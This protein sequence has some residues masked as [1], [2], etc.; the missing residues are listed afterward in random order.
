MKNERDLFL[1]PFFTSILIGIIIGHFYFFSENN[2]FIY[3]EFK[4][5]Y[6][7]ILLHA[8]LI[9]FGYE[10]GLNL[11]YNS[12]INGISQKSNELKKQLLIQNGFTKKE[13]KRNSGDDKYIFIIGDSYMDN[14]FQYGESSYPYL[15]KKFSDSLN[16]GFVDLSKSGTDFDY[17]NETLN[18][19]N[20]KNSILVYSFYINDY[21]TIK[22]KKKKD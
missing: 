16:Y 5:K 19:L 10:L 8:F 17:F 2:Q 4:K 9:Y 11:D 7:K 18:N 3:F 13:L 12:N 14:L 15:F 21:P 22:K 20:Y 1:N 6:L